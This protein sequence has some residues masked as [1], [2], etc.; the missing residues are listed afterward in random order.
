[1]VWSMVSLVLSVGSPAE[2]RVHGPRIGD[3]V[4][5][6]CYGLQD[7]FDALVAEAATGPSAQRQ[8]EI[9]RRLLEILDE[10]DTICSGDFGSIIFYRR[11]PVCEVEGGKSCVP[12]EDLLVD[13]DRDGMVDLYEDGVTRDPRSWD[14]DGNGVADGSDLE[15]LLKGI[16]ALTAEDLELGPKDDRDAVVA[17]LSDW[18]PKL[19][20]GKEGLAAAS[21][22][23][24]SLGCETEKV[25]PERITA[26]CE[27]VDRLG[28][29]A[30]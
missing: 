13:R 16:S 2:A 22:L 11:E 20:G 28:T 17:A 5:L 14:T 4:R 25:D 29:T 9:A 23:Q 3:S 18:A 8:E 19:E 6:G 24:E 7:E 26:V 1:M 12:L 21:A 10:W 30:R 27:E 15:P